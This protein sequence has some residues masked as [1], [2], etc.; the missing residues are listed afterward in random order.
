MRHR[1]N[2]QRQSARDDAPAFLIP[3]FPLVPTGPG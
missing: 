2:D 1:D 3:G